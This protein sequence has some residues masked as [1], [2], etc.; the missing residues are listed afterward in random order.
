MRAGS[1]SPHR[2]FNPAPRLAGLLI[3]LLLLLALGAACESRSE[4]S[5]ASDSSDPAPTTDAPVRIAGIIFSEDQFFHLIQLGMKHAAREAGAHLLLENSHSRPD[6]E[7]ALVNTYLTQGIDAIVISPLSF[8]GSYTAL[9][10]AVDQGARVVT[11]NTDVSGGLASSF[12]ESDQF[13]LGASTGKVARE[14]IEQHLGGKAKVAI[15]AFMR[16]APET[17]LQRVNGFKSEVTQLP[18]VEIVA[19][20]DAWL[21]DMSVKKTGD[22]LAANPDINVIWSANEGGTLGAA[23]AVINTGRAGRIAVFGTDANEQLADLLLADD[24]TLQAITSQQPFE[25][26]ALAVHT[27]IKVVRGEP[28]QQQVSLPGILLTRSDPDGVRRFKTRLQ[29]LIQ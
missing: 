17:S 16:S 8:K 23:L 6:R 11:Y 19:E 22:I 3:L 27:A 15:L 28:V 10:R 13:S 12:I 25:I 24:N 18:G 1:H 9:K 26:G 4:G 20:Q 2:V 7:I 29:E 5:R 14:Y 21:A